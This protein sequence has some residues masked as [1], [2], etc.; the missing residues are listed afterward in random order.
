[1]LLGPLAKFGFAALNTY[2]KQFAW[3]ISI[4]AVMSFFMCA[5]LVFYGQS[6]D[7]DI[8]RAL[9]WA[10]GKLALRG[11][12]GVSLLALSWQQEEFE[13]GIMSF[14]YHGDADWATTARIQRQCVCE[15]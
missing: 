6:Q 15:V 1:M 4:I 12:A 9:S 5:T 2:R 3:L 10:S 8:I 14:A 7:Y 11:D 13:L